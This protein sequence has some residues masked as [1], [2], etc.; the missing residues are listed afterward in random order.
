MRGGGGEVQYVSNLSFSS[1]TWQIFAVC[2]CSNGIFLDAPAKTREYKIRVDKL[3]KTYN[4]TCTEIAASQPFWKPR[5]LGPFSLSH[6]SAKILRLPLKHYYR[7][8][9]G[10]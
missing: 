8:L 9:C 7:T 3:N 4:V 10:N 5:L 6:L 1:C 2:C